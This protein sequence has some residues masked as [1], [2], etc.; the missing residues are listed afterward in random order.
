MSR[1]TGFVLGY[2]G[3]ERAIGHKIVCG[4]LPFTQSEK[5]FDWL[6]HGIYFWEADRQRALEWAKWKRFTEPCV[7]GA[8][9]DLR[10]CFDLLERENLDLLALTYDSF[11][12][13]R[14]AAGLAVPLN[15]D[16]VKGA[17]QNKVMRFLDC[18][19]INHLHETINAQSIPAFDTVRGLFVEGEPAYEGSEIYRLTHSQIAVRNVD[20]I[21]GVFFPR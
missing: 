19:V 13:S 1:A 16:S 15:R 12:K 3:C 4:E 11:V 8:V 6:G 2:H 18:A 7:I 9:L 17:S 20:C 14:K 10:N 21:R 5:S